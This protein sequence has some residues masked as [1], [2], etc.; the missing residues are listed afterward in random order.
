MAA[1][2]VVA[3]VFVAPL[4]GIG[5]YFIAAGSWKLP[6]AWGILV[7]LWL[8]CAGAA[9]RF[10][11]SLIRE[12]VSPGPGNRDHLTRPASAL[13]ILAHWI[14][15]GI[16]VGRTHW[17]P[18]PVALQWIGVVGYALSM[19]GM[20]WAMRANP[21]YSSVVRIQADRGQRAVTTGPYRFVRHP[22]YTFTALAIVTG[23]LA[24]GSWVGMLPL[25]AVIA[26]F[27]RR[28]LLEDRM[29]H[30]ELGGYAEYAGRV[31]YRLVAGVF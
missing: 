16:D 7:V 29:L 3:A 31:R 15:A 5:I 8:F 18:V 1:V 27:V 26:L 17:S 28:T 2:K 19:A 21:Y 22:G 25:V 13:L 10:D 6:P 12:R 4:V 11:R 23:G 20:L 30:R 14:L 24:L 9:V